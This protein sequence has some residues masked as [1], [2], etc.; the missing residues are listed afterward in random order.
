MKIVSINK[1]INAR[2]NSGKNHN[3]KHHYLIIERLLIKA[4]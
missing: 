2:L 4:S 1:L 3:E